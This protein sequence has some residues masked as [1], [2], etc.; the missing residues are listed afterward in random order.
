MATPALP[1]SPMLC[2]RLAGRPLL[3]LLDVDGTL[4]PIAE[5]PEYAAVP[6]ATQRVLA[7][8]V[9]LPDTP[10]AIVSGRS[11]RDA[12]RL[13]GVKGVWVLGNHG[14]EFARPNSPPAV[15]R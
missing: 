10:V 1:L 12:R 6:P 5:R 3:L 14:I 11:A 9:G 8:L 7:E 2:N 4:A 15:R 13:V